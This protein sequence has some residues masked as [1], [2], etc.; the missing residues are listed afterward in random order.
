MSDQFEWHISDE[1]EDQGNLQRPK[2]NG[3]PRLPIHPLW[4]VAVVVIVGGLF[5]GRQIINQNDELADALVTA[6]QDLLDLE[7]EAYLAGNGP[8]FL[9]AFSNDIGWQTAQLL[10]FNQEKARAGLHVTHAEQFNNNIRVDVAWEVDG[11]EHQNAAFFRQQSAQI[12]HVPPPG[13]F[14][15][16]PQQESYGWGSLNLYEAD[17]EWQRDIGNFVDSVVSEVCAQ[18]CDEARFPFRVMVRD[19]YR[20]TPVEGEIYVPSPYLMALDEDGRPASIFWDLLE[21]KVTAYLAPAVIRFGIPP[22]GTLPAVQYQ[23]AADEFMQLHPDIT[24]ELILL[25]SDTPDPAQLTALDGAALI[26]SE[27]LITNGLVHDLTDFALEDGDL[28]PNDFY[29]QVWPASFWRER[30][31][32]VPHVAEMNLL[33]YDRMGYQ[34]ADQP[35]PSLRW[36]WEEMAEDMAAV[37]N[38]VTDS[39]IE[40]GFLDV[41]RNTLFSYAYNWK[42]ECTEER[43]VRCD[44]SLE[45]QAAAAALS[46]YQQMVTS[47]QMPNVTELNVEESQSLLLNFQSARRHALVWV[48]RPIQYEHHLLLDA[49]GVLPFPGSDRFD[50]ITPLWIRGNIIMQHSERPLAVWEWIKFLSHQPP[51]QHLRL[52]PA[53]PSVANS[54]GYWAKLPLPLGNAMRTAFPFA[55][56]VLIE[57]QAYFSKEQVA[58]VVSGA[59]TADEAASEWPNLD[60]FAL[61]SG[62]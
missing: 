61:T 20:D 22:G 9:S 21:Q 11:E 49:I 47:E 36:T 55:H 10:P 7:H 35:E 57:E 17:W 1:E 2:S 26:L 8:L 25:D 33:F 24:I 15:G 27:E 12:V 3:G 38:A 50:G 23:E 40:W 42:N 31:W 59:M 56:P 29:E 41:T 39:D 34:A 4:V 44:R 46:W 54:I 52:I 32:Q 37:V 60:W 28:M 18:A 51:V 48:E 30:M 19:D 58:A 43:T 16:L 5:A 62:R 45:P 14:W 13:D 53:R 6:V